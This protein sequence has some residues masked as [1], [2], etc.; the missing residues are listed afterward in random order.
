MNEWMQEANCRG[1][2]PDLMVPDSASYEGNSPAELK[3]TKL[4]EG[5]P[6]IEECLYWGMVTGSQGVFGGTTTRQRIRMRREAR[7]ARGQTANTPI[8]GL[9]VPG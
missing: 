7:I 4:C 6:V 2:D 3:A 8:S 9:F 1:I 5:C